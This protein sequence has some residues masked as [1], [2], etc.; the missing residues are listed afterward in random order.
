MKDHGKSIKALS[1]SQDLPEE[2]AQL[3]AEQQSALE[4]VLATQQA[5]LKKVLSQLVAAHQAA[6]SECE[7][8]RNLLVTATAEKDQLA[9]VNQAL[10]RSQELE[11]NNSLSNRIGNVIIRAADSPSSIAGLPFKLRKFWRESKA[12]RPPKS[13]GGESFSKVLAAYADGGF[14]AVKVLMD[15]LS[16]SPTVKANGYTAL[17]RHLKNDTPELACEA[18]CYAYEEDP[19]PFRRKWLAFRLYEAGDVLGA[20]ILLNTLSENM[21]L[22]ASEMSL[23][24]KISLLAKGIHTSNAQTKLT[25]YYEKA[26][27]LLADEPD[28]PK[29]RYSAVTEYHNT[30]LSETDADGQSPQKM[31]RRIFSLPEKENG[32]LLNSDTHKKARVACVMDDFTFLSYAPECQIC[33]LTPDD[34]IEEL[35]AFQPDILFIESAWRG[36]DN[37]WDKKIGHLCHELRNVI[38]WCK[39][40][41]IP[42]AF[43]NKE[44]PI[45]FETFLSTAQQFDYVFTT[46]IDC[47]A[48]YKAILGHDKVYLLPFACQ[49]QLHNPVERYPRKDAFCF[50]G[51]Y[52]VRYPER[53]ATLKN[54]VAE[55]TKF[56]PLE[57]FDRNLNKDDANYKFPE[58]YQPFIVGN[59]PFEEIDKAYKG[60]KYAINL[61]SMTQSQTMFARR[62]YELLGSNTLTI[63]NF[64]RGLRLLF[65]DI[66]I[67]CDDGQEIVKRLLDLD[68]ESADKVR[69]AGLRKVMLEHCYAHRMQYMLHKVL[70]WQNTHLLPVM[71]FLAL[72]DSKEQYK[73]ILTCFQSQAHISKRLLVILKKNIAKKQLPAA[74]KDED[75]S[76]M[77][78]SEAAKLPI[79]S[80]VRQ[81]EWV[82]LM[83]PEDYYGPNY[84]LDIALATQYSDA[85]LIGKATRYQW[86]PSGITLFEPGSTYSPTQG[87]PARC[88]AVHV[89]ALPKEITFSSLFADNACLEKEWEIP[90]LA[91]DAFNYCQG[92][93]LAKDR[94]SLYARVDDLN[95]HTGLSLDEVIRVAEGIKPAVIEHV[96]KSTWDGD[97]L[98]DLFKRVNRPQIHIEDIEE[99][100]CLHSTLSDGMHDYLYATQEFSLETLA[101]DGEIQSHL[102]ASP[103]LHISY[104]FFFLDK[105][106]NKISHVIHA[107]NKNCTDTTPEGTSF[108]RFGLRIYNSGQA[109]IKKLIWGHRNLEP[110]TLLNRSNILLLT[111]H[112]PS[113]DDL[114]RTAFVHSRVKAYE[115]RGI[116][117][118][119]FRLRPGEPLV[120]HEFQNI[121]VATGGKNALLKLLDGE[122]Y[123]HVLVHFISPDMWDILKLYPQLKIITW[124]HGAEI[125]PWYRRAFNYQTEQERE[126][127]MVIS[128]QRMTFWKEVISN[129]SHNI[130]LV[131][132]SQYLADQS[133]VDLDM[134]I[135]TKAYSVIHNPIDTYLFS[136]SKKQEKDRANILSIRPYT[137]RTYANDLTAN[138]I[139]LLK[140]KP[141]FN[142]L[143]FLL[144]GNGELFE[145]TVAPLRRF[146]NITL[147]KCFLTQAEIADLHKHYGIFLVPTRMDTQGV[148]RDEAMSSGLVPVTNRVAAVPEFVDE[149]CGLLAEPEE[150]IGL[151]L[152]IEKIYR[153]P[154]LFTQLSESAAKRVRQRCDIDTI[155]SKEFELMN[156]TTSYTSTP[157]I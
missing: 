52:Y 87:L 46:D 1:S 127:A 126:K 115:K 117:A 12:Q 113:Y 143:S 136:Y 72:A 118:D 44:D 43:W 13:L 129:L 139:L 71:V 62:I 81:G 106:K 128:E 100:L 79:S 89:D 38:D 56:R 48:R 88:S 24:K 63:S 91:I 75:I 27:D 68:E 54:Y 17:A 140:D 111:N 83:N 85:P 120:F 155:I 110:E 73:Q 150:A 42:T 102:E 148:S 132:V 138:A 51:A 154:E 114:Y 108:I 58:E 112:Y 151:A 40:R 2:L 74:D 11:L 147:K 3:L 93:Q 109:V 5:S 36:K 25:R 98:H 122:Q 94:E 90:G 157:H 78:L 95:M 32:P 37:L 7:N 61:N 57:I 9:A 26:I 131:F 116:N 29:V 67:S 145:E 22:S 34:A 84:L 134:R 10:F 28:E 141:F 55:L 97:Y 104:V 69:L 31:L 16:V 76:I 133:M 99:G 50:A 20:G 66:V 82:A 21:P 121:D 19:Q 53:N 4:Q 39:E 18:A 119:V 30:D 123:T 8:L 86:T 103:G 96:N 14:D 77:D 144:I 130:H 149:S 137:S 47:I 124:I 152:A 6:E 59:L 153:S 92:G 142:E 23:A 105:D 65:G 49:P 33:P 125:Q 41:Q 80:F 45:H 60:Y 156:I 70:G 64:S 107:A 146:P 35:E 101:I 15:E 135:P